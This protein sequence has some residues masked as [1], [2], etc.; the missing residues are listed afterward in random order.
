MFTDSYEK[1]FKDKNRILAIFAHPDDADI[2]AG[3]TLARLVKEGKQVGSV[4]LSLGNKGSRQENI[5]EEALSAL[6]LEE[7]K[8]AMKVLGIKDNDN[9]YLDFSD[10]EI[11]NTL[12]TIEKL[13]KVIRTFKPDIVIT[14]NPED[15]IIRWDGETNWVNHRDHRNTGKSVVDACYP[16]S[17]DILF[18]PEQFTDPQVQSHKVTEFLF[19]DYFDHPDTIAIDVTE[20]ADVRTNAIASHSSQYSQED[21]Q[22]STDFFTKL[23]DSGNRYERFRYVFAD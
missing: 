3:G 13:V 1:I 7:D 19:V 2:Y 17:R 5:T 9:F 10:G 18:F 12:S 11:E 20:S 8:A 6:R 23:D 16:Y 4:K 21:A 15:M 22:D 14:H